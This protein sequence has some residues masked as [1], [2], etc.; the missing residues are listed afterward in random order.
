MLNGIVCDKK[1][2]KSQKMID[3]NE[4]G[5]NFTPLFRKFCD[6]EK[7][8]DI[9]GIISSNYHNRYEIRDIVY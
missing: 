4:K 5:N 6:T 3:I 9:Y 2:L 8:T 7:T 1:L